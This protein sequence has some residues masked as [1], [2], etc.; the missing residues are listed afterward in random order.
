[1]K[2]ESLPHG[3]FPFLFT[4]ILGRLN[5]VSKELGLVGALTP[6]FIK[7]EYP[8]MTSTSATVSCSK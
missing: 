1:M 6:V 7:G 3:A 8:F 4:Y 2:L 5:Q